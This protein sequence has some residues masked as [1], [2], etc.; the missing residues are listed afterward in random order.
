[1]EVEW[2]LGSVIAA[3]PSA[4]EASGAQPTEASGMDAALVF[5]SA[6]LTLGVGVLLFHVACSAGAR[7]VGQRDK[8]AAGADGLLSAKACPSLFLAT[9]AALLGAY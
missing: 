8:A 1:M 9:K 2:T 7:K 6:L 3:G 4:L 5:F